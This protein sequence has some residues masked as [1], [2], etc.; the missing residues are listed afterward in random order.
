[1]LGG[2]CF[3]PHSNDVRERKTTLKLHSR[4]PSLLQDF[5][6]VSGIFGSTAE[7]GQFLTCDS[8]ASR[9]FERMIDIQ[10]ISL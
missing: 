5:H 8:M 1:V 10:N 9:P 4:T 7:Y 6:L 2:G 3:K